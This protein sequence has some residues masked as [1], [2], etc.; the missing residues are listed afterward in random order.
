MLQ[1]LSLSNISCLGLRVR[2]GRLLCSPHQDSEG[3]LLLSSLLFVGLS[4]DLEAQLPLHT[5]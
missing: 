2:A 5:E 1:G 3:P 4:P